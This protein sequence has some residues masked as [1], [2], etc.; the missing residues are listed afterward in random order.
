M[1][2]TL[3][4]VSDNT[5]AEEPASEPADA[6]EPEATEPEATPEDTVESGPP[7]QQWNTFA[8]SRRLG[9]AVRSQRTAGFVAGVND[10]I[11]T[12]RRERKLGKGTLRDTYVAAYRGYVA[13]GRVHLRLRITEEPVVPSPA[14][15]LADPDVLRTN[16]RRFFT[17]PFP[18]VKAQ[19]S[20]AG[21]TDRVESDRRGYATCNMPV[22]DLVSGWHDYLVTTEPDDADEEPTVV[23]SQL[24][25][26]D[27]TADVCV[28]SDID[29]TIL[30]TGL[31]EGLTAV[32]N[33]LFGQAR[34]RRA[35]PGMSTL[36]RAIE[37]GMPGV[38]RA[39]FFYVSTGPWNLYDVLTDF[40]SVRGF[41]A[42]P[43][44]LT[45]W[46]PQERYVTRSG[47]EH[48]RSTLRRLFDHFPD[49][50]FV[51]IGDA[52]QKDAENYTL[53]A[54]EHPEQVAAILIL[55][56]GLSDK[57]AEAE[58]RETVARS[59]GVEFRFVADARHAAQVLADLGI[60]PE[61]SV[62]AVAAAYERV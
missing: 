55:D 52:G 20:A 56:V 42:G 41:P 49:S 4:P 30:Q 47:T 37:A 31:A 7:P 14:A 54:K 25:V 50:R 12:F 28:I 51:L 43:L 24:L 44:F 61:A 33:T 17:L 45:D 39:A 23:R 58:E 62:T 21:A 22:G 2:A 26:P 19:V 6:P 32:K 59:A 15:A 40:M 11:G 5:T 13:Q 3:A 9:R 53:M 57:A 35:V 10:R 29:D 60:I 34:S 27:P 36:Y 16:L 46:G 48:K 18:G 8:G 1:C 38:G